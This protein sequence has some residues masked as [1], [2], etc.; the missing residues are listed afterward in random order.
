MQYYIGV[1]TSFLSRTN[2]SDK[3]GGKHTIQKVSLFVFVFFATYL[4]YDFTFWSWKADNLA[5]RLFPQ[6]IILSNSDI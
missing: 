1:L 6:Q 5:M 3:T 2:V 4:E